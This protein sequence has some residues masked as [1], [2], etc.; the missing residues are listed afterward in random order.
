[1]K[2]TRSF[3]KFLAFL[4]LSLTLYS[5]HAQ[6][7]I[8]SDQIETGANPFTMTDNGNGTV[9]IINL[10]ASGSGSSSGNLK[11]FNLYDNSMKGYNVGTRLVA[12][13]FAKDYI[14]LINEDQDYVIV[15]TLEGAEVAEIKVGARPS[16]VYVTTDSNKVF[17][18]NGDGSISLI[19]IS[20]GIPSS[21]ALYQSSESNVIGLDPRDIYVD[22]DYIYLISKNEVNGNSF[23]RKL[24]L[25]QGQVTKEKEVEVG[26]DAISLGVSDN[27]FVIVNNGSFSV[28]LIKKADFSKQ[29]LHLALLGAKSVTVN[30]ENNIDYAYVASFFDNFV[31]KINLSNSEV[32]YVQLASD[33]VGFSDIAFVN[34]QMLATQFTSGLLYIYDV[35]PNQVMN[36][37]PAIIEYKSISLPNTDG[38]GP[39]PYSKP[40]AIH[41]TVSKSCNNRDKCYDSLT[42]AVQNIPSVSSACSYE[43]HVIYIETGIYGSNEV[44]PIGSEGTGIKAIPSCVSL[45]GDVNG[46]AVI[47][48]TTATTNVIQ[49]AGASNILIEGL[50]IQNAPL[51]QSGVFIAG[52]AQAPTENIT[53]RNNTLKYNGRNGFGATGVSNLLIQNNKV[54]FN[55]ETGITVSALVINSD[56]TYK[57]VPNASTVR[58]IDNISQYNIA[59]GILVTSSS[60]A[61]VQG[62]HAHANGVAGIEFNGRD[63][64]GPD[65]RSADAKLEGIINN[66]YAYNNGGQQF[67]NS[68]AGIL[69]TEEAN[70]LEVIGNDVKGNRPYGIGVYER[71]LM[72]DDGTALN[73]CSNRGIEDNKVESNLQGGIVVHKDSSVCKIVNNRLLANLG[74]GIDIQGSDVLYVSNNQTVS[75]G[76]TIPERGISILY[77][78]GKAS[79]VY[80]LDGNTFNANQIGIE[81]Q[82]STVKCATN[83]SV[84]LN[85][86]EGLH[87]EAGAA[88]NTSCEGGGNSYQGNGAGIIVDNSIFND[89]KAT[90][91]NNTG[92]GVDIRGNATVVLSSSSILNNKGSEGGVRVD[93]ENKVTLNNNLI[94]GNYRKDSSNPENVVS[95]KSDIFVSANTT[96]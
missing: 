84:D 94:E 72:S 15:T 23:F 12:S 25:S 87:I 67:P 31:A 46:G 1:M 5:V 95:Q 54:E 81:V 30:K 86:L 52:L 16:N 14:F 83:N 65:Q 70:A 28:S 50:T 92:T 78:D 90:I 36:P 45:V 2:I 53:I 56:G 58:I 17:A 75:D 77:R 42:Q 22:G 93:R 89:T 69:V 44:F 33:K 60:S 91:A 66:N 20:N 41:A 73:N 61:T 39:Q 62:N 10:V 49:I 51:L 59:D 34:G 32:D 11:I 37:K 55:R 24:R 40:S 7:N 88:F 71:G 76:V 6:V 64:S 35:I 21:S 79:S 29:E 26:A 48:G 18:T 63:F 82:N 13:A 85:T 19:D 74:V 27:Y 9:T 3:Y 43:R 57:Y 8:P 47:D 4:L 38:K 96:P 68:G 80:S